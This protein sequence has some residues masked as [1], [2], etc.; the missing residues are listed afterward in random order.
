VNWAWQFEA[1]ALREFRQLDFAAQKRIVGF[2]DTRI[3]TPHD[4]RRF[5]KFMSGDKHGLWRYRIGDHRL[6]AQIQT[7]ILVVLVVR[8]GHRKDV[9]DF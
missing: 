8:V 1:G 3:A 2:P 9:Y 5:G 7:N 6:V 4:P